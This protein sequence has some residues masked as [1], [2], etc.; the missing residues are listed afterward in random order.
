MTIVRDDEC[1]QLFEY[2]DILG[3]HYL[4]TE[5]EA[6][7]CSV[8]RVKPM[9]PPG[10]IVG[11]ETI[12]HCGHRGIDFQNGDRVCVETCGAKKEYV[13]TYYDEGASC[14]TV[15]ETPLWRRV[16]SYIWGKLVKFAEWVKP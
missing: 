6:S 8:R 5:K 1:D 7:K 14:I 15:R 13:V 11:P 12:I 9:P 16:M 3:N 4:M 10:R 2:V